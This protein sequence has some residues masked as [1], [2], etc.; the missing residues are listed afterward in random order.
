[1]PAINDGEI[2]AL[3][4]LV[5]G[6]YLQERFRVLRDTGQLD[7]TFESVVVKYKDLFTSDAVDAAKW[8]LEN[9]NNL[10]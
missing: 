9:A 8:R 1:L 2:E 7:K 5:V 10:I 4:R 6:A 3:S